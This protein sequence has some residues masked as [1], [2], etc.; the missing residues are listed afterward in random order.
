MTGRD[1]VTGAVI[2]G[3]VVEGI[4]CSCVIIIVVVVF[5][6]VLVRL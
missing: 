3:E 5:I 4:E 2:L 1:S 6:V